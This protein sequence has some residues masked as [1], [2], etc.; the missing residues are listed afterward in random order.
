MCKK[1][2]LFHLKVKD[3]VCNFR[4]QIKNPLSIQ[5]LIIQPGWTENHPNSI[6]L[7]LNSQEVKRSQKN[8]LRRKVGEP[9]SNNFTCLNPNTVAIQTPMRAIATVATL[10]FSEIPGAGGGGRVQSTRTFE[11]GGRDWHRLD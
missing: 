5:A 10:Q 7:S 11:N 3:R 8:G 1:K 9:T 6:L 4:R 2:S